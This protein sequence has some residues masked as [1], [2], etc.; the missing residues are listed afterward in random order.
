M[1]VPDSLTSV[2]GQ[3]WM[4][5]ACSL[6]NY[7]CGDTLNS[8]RDTSPLVWLVEEEE[9]LVI[10]KQKRGRGSL[11]VKV[12]DS[13]QVCPEFEPLKAK[14]AKGA[15][16][17]KSVKAQMSFRRCG[18]EVKRGSVSLGVVQPKILL[19]LPT[20]NN[21]NQKERSHSEYFSTSE[22]NV[23]EIFKFN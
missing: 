14:R 12:P 17:R 11:V 13:S 7:V 3:E 6:D 16:A 4:F 8:Y 23:S 2:I 1:N 5:S 18:V 20:E 10:P 22:A 15:G 19:S 21:Y 9:S